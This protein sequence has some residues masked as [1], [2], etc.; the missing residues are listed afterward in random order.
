MAFDEYTGGILEKIGYLIDETDMEVDQINVS[1]YNRANGKSIETG[2]T[3][4]P[5][6]ERD[7]MSLSDGEPSEHGLDSTVSPALVDAFNAVL[8]LDSTYDFEACEDMV[9]ADDISVMFMV[10]LANIS[11]RT[12]KQSLDAVMDV[13]ND[14][15]ID[16]DNV[17]VTIY[18]DSGYSFEFGWCER[19]TDEAID[20]MYDLEDPDVVENDTVDTLREAVQEVVNLETPYAPYGYAVTVDL[21]DIS[22]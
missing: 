13:L 9:G 15:D 18:D 14:P 17:E 8:S 5:I 16:T 1:F 12:P 11:G 4:P 3:D 10:P 19:V 2:V 7:V 22:F 6:T 20:G 21:N